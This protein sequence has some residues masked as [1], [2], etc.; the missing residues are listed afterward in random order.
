LKNISLCDEDVKIF[1]L[2][3]ETGEGRDDV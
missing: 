3:Y 1:A 2:D